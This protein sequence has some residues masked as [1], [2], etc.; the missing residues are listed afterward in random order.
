M[1]SI[2]QSTTNGSLTIGGSGTGRTS[3]NQ[4]GPPPS[5]RHRSYQ[6]SSVTVKTTLGKMIDAA[7]NQKRGVK[8]SHVL[9]YCK[10]HCVVR[11]WSHDS[12]DNDDTNRYQEIVRLESPLQPHYVANDDLQSELAVSQTGQSVLRQALP[13]APLSILRLLIHLG[14]QAVRHVNVVNGRM[15]LHTACRF[16]P[17]PQINEAL[18]LL[19]TAH[20]AALVHRCRHGQT[21]LHYLFL[22][23]APQR[24]PE[25]T[26]HFVR[27]LQSHKQL[28]Y[29]LRQ[30]TTAA[31]TAAASSSSSTPITDT[32]TTTATRR[33]PDIPKPGCTSSAGGSTDSTKKIPYN[34][35]IV[36]DAVHGCLPLHYAALHGAPL[37]TL[38]VLYTAFPAAKHFG[39][40]HGRTPLHWYLG[41]GTLDPV[42]PVTVAGESLSE[43]STWAEDESMSS[44]LGLQQQQ[45]RRKQEDPLSLHYS[46]HLDYPVV[47]LLLSSRV[48]R[49]MDYQGRHVLHWIVTYIAYHSMLSLHALANCATDNEESAWPLL[50]IVQLL[51]DSATL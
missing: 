13:V 43:L 11:E 37:S 47:Q 3:H 1:E 25:I 4:D 44:S 22:H 48:A 38:H 32:A 28:F 20:P 6:S 21:P 5:Q 12:D 26:K 29:T 7:A 10:A 46:R 36:P 45:P 9:H 50:S 15:L 18:S 42:R 40:S 2:S 49:T 8:W 14:P 33:L 27:N 24:T 34:A 35:A 17:S 31:T 39:D 30:P 41:A 51:L 16:P 23:F 19:I